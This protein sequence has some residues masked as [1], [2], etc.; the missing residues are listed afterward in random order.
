MVQLKQTTL[1]ENSIELNILQQMVCGGK[2]IT[3][4]LT[5]CSLYALCIYLMQLLSYQHTD[6]R[7]DHQVQTAN[8]TDK[9]D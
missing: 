2:Y 6:Q 9:Q 8:C 5:V 3:L 4:K 7:D 1:S